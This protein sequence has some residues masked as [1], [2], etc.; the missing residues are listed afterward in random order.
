[1]KITPNGFIKKF[2]GTYN[3]GNS[4]YFQTSIRLFA[5]HPVWMHYLELLYKSGL[6]QQPSEKNGDID[7]ESAQTKQCFLRKLYELVNKPEINDI[8]REPGSTKLKEQKALFEEIYTMYQKITHNIH[9]GVNDQG[10]CNETIGA[11]TE[12]MVK[13]ISKVM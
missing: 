1:M 5:C 11:I 4:C 13:L 12:I 7:G 9:N 2:Q 6:A 10:S 8:Y 3:A